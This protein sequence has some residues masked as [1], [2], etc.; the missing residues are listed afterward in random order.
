MGIHVIVPTCHFHNCTSENAR[1]FF[2]LDSCGPCQVMIFFSAHGVPLSYVKDAGDPYK[3]QM[4]ECISLIME[5]LRSRGVD[6]PHILAYQVLGWSFFLVIFLQFVDRLSFTIPDPLSLSSNSLTPATL[7]NQS[8]VGPVQWLKPYTDEVIVELGQQGTKSLLA[9]PVRYAALCQLIRLKCQRQTFRE[10]PTKEVKPCV[11]LCQLCERAHRNLGGD[12]HG[13]QG[14]G[15]GVGNRELGQSAHARLQLLL[16]RRSGRRRDRSPPIRLSSRRLQEPW[17]RNRRRP[18]SES[19]QRVLRLA[20]RLHPA[21]GAE[22][23][24]SNEKRCPLAGLAAPR[25]P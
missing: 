12:R 11:F 1:R 18:S 5:E 6:N 23:S 3:E 15:L 16:H 22:V 25:R 9:V 20:L 13:V 24:S 4:E 21:P 14:I 19:D 7:Q 2:L 17:N 8:R 10:K